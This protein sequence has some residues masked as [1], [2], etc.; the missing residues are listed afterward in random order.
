MLGLGCGVMR[1]TLDEMEDVYMD[2]G[3]RIFSAS[4]SDPPPPAPVATEQGSTAASQ[5]WG[6]GLMRLYRSGEQGM[7]VAMYGAKHNTA[8]FEQLLQERTDLTTLGTLSDRTIDATCLAG[9]KVCVFAC[10]SCLGFSCA[11]ARFP[12]SVPCSG[13]LGSP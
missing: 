2:L 3:S 6:E 11:A 4:S 12:L 8:L 10:S 1:F 7:R 5:S 13:H 9:P